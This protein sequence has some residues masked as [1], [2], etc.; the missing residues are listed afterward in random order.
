M[1]FLIERGAQL[2]ARDK[3][4]NVINAIAW[5][6]PQAMEEFEKLLDT[7]I[8]MNKDEAIIT[9]NFTKI[10]QIDKMK[11]ETLE[12]S[13]FSDLDQSQFKELIEHPLCLVFIHQVL[14]KKL[15]WYYVFFIMVPHWLFSTIY[16][17]YCGVFFGYLCVP[18]NNS[19]RWDLLERIP[20]VD[21]DM[22]SNEVYWSFH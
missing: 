20:C 5:N 1:R 15:L 16:S 10:F 9:L 4:E 2:N 11:E 7:G 6:V 17:F 19:S 3:D 14:F 12:T 18:K 21:V 13:L 22:D 8:T